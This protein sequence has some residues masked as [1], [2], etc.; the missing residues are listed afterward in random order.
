VVTE[1]GE[2]LFTGQDITAGQQLI[3]AR[4]LMQYGS[5][6]G[7]AAY[8]GPDYTADYLRRSTDFVE[9]QLRN[10]GAPTRARW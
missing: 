5:I 10:A 4:G 9:T 3:L 8:L 2:V 6:V 1:N 7:H